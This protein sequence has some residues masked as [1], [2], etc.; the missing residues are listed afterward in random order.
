MDSEARQRSQRQRRRERARELQQQ[1]EREREAQLQAARERERNVQQPEGE[2]GE[3]RE[4][5]RPAPRPAS[6]PASR[7]S[8]EEDTSPPAHRERPRPR[9]RKQRR[10]S[11]SA[12]SQE[13][14]I[15][16]GFAIS[17]FSSMDALENESPNKLVDRRNR[18]KAPLDGGW[19]TE[20]TGRRRNVARRPSSFGHVGQLMPGKPDVGLLR[21]A[22]GIQMV[23]YESTDCQGSVV[24]CNATLGFELAHL[25]IRRASPHDLPSLPTQQD[26]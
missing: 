19:K 17:S 14:D 6:R 7:Q 2:G 9:P 8:A 16:D 26:D 22:D 21:K 18:D 5:S 1:R 13:E 12:S 11:H 3:D 24:F 25:N 20:R 15:I 4:N 23:K 10:E